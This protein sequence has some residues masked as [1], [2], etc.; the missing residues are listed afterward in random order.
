VCEQQI[1]AVPSRC[2]NI[3]DNNQEQCQ[4]AASLVCRKSP[5]PPNVQRQSNASSAQASNCVG[6]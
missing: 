6:F 3:K 2:Q 4:A 5:S 1:P